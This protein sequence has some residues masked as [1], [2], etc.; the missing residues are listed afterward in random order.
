MNDL[1]ACPFCGPGT[2]IVVLES[3]PGFFGPQ[4]QRCGGRTQHV[5]VAKAV[6]IWN[7][8]DGF[9]ADDHEA[10]TTVWLYAVGFLNDRMAC[11]ALGSL[12]IQ[13]GRYACIRSVPIPTPETRGD[14]R[15]LCKCLGIE[16]RQV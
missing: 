15:R 9:P 11:P 1:K 12:H 5:D 14:V 8:R 13:P 6:A 4:C 7:G 10:V 16:L 3:S 2:A